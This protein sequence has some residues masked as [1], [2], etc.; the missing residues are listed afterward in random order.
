[1]RGHRGQRAAGGGVLLQAD[2]S[3]RDIEERENRGKTTGLGNY[4]V[5]GDLASCLCRW[6]PVHQAVHP[7]PAVTPG[8]SLLQGSPPRR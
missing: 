4:E 2:S 7:P 5:T 6:H 8:L 3:F 1:M